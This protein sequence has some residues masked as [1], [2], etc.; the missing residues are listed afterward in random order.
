[1]VEYLYNTIRAVSGEDIE[2]SAFITDPSD[3][4][5]TQDCS[6][7]FWDNEK[8]LIEVQGNYLSD[9][10]GWSFIVPSDITKGLKGR[11]WYCLRREGKDLC[12]KQPIYL[13][14]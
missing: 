11:Y 5:I 6:L 2:V 12:F 9:A 7:S 8:E 10:L 1:M 3:V 14:Y 13:E 4:P